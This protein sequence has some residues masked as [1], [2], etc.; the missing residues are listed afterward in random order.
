MSPS[1]EAQ[2]ECAFDMLDVNGTG[3]ISGE[4]IGVF[5]MVIAPASTTKYGIDVL[6]QVIME[7]ADPIASINGTLSL[8]DFLSWPG[9][10]EVVQWLS[11][12]HARI[13]SRIQ[14]LADGSNESAPS[15]VYPWAGSTTDELIQMARSEP[16]KGGV[17]IGEF[18]RVLIK[19]G[20]NGADLGEPLF[21]ALD[22]DSE[23]TLHYTPM[24][25]GLAILLAQSTEAL[26]AFTLAT[27][28]TLATTGGMP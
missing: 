21:D 26:P 16:R 2:L 9:S 27:L 28:A 23:G 10:S 5:L 6:T 12:Y 11:E 8:A 24:F 22:R 13:T 25:T 19:L 1:H 4:E 14:A 7:H 17:S 20:L 3:R 15:K 18:Q